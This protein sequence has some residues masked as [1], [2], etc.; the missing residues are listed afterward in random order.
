MPNLTPT[1]DL[2][3]IAELKNLLEELSASLMQREENLAKAL[4]N[5]Q[6][7]DELSRVI[8]ELRTPVREMKNHTEIFAAKAEALIDDIQLREILNQ[9]I[10]N[11]DKNLT[12]YLQKA[13]ANV[14]K[15]SSEMNSSLKEVILINSNLVQKFSAYLAVTTQN[16]QE[17]NQILNK[18]KSLSLMMI[19]GFIFASV[20]PLIVIYVNPP[21]SPRHSKV[22]DALYER[23]FPDNPSDKK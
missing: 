3:E 14:L 4:S 2:Q 19:L 10:E 17:Q 6:K 20:L 21:V 22:L 13:S 15:I 7:W 18:V 16:K 8:A 1:L 23:I 5:L 11:Q 9:A 12:D